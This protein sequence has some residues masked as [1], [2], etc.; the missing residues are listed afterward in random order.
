MIATN[1]PRSM[2]RSTSCSATTS[3]SR[4][5]RIDLA[6]A[7]GLDHRRAAMHAARALI[8]RSRRALADDDERRLRFRSP[9]ETS[10]TL[11]SLAPTR[12]ITGCGLPS[13][14]LYSGARARAEPAPRAPRP[15]CCC[16]RRRGVAR[17]AAKS[18]LKRSG[19]ALPHLRLRRR[20]CRRRPIA[21]MPRPPP[22]ATAAEQRGCRR[23]LRRRPARAACARALRQRGVERRL[24]C[25]VELQRRRDARQLV[26]HAAAARRAAAAASRPARRPVVG[27]L[28]AQR[29]VR[30][31]F[32]TSSRR[33]TSISA[34]AVM[35]GSSAAVA[36]STVDHHRIGDHVVG[37]G[38]RQPHLLA[39][40]RGTGARG[41]HR[42]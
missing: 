32:S 5:G 8:A 42:R 35:P 16:C 22:A 7:A 28:E 23:L 9:P 17:N 11:P 2:R 15:S 30:T 36:L 34:F 31:R 20:R 37:V 21:T 33:L 41:R 27:R 14:S 1:S 18:C 24:L 10:V 26:G 3:A 12:T 39:P 29:R 40:C 4:A 25:G 19:H 6:Q 13:T 38:R